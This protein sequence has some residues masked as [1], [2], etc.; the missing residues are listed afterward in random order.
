MPAVFWSEYLV[1]GNNFGDLGVDDIIT[2][3]LILK[4][5]VEIWALD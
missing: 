5:W 1:G 3:K 4:P 2:Y